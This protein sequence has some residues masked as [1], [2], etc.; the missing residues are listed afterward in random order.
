M[1][2][3]D[4]C[5]RNSCVWCTFCFNCLLSSVVFTNASPFYNTMEAI[6]KNQCGQ[7]FSE[8]QTKQIYHCTCKISRCKLS[9]VLTSRQN[10]YSPSSRAEI[11]TQLSST[12]CFHKLT[13][14]SPVDTASTLPVTDQL[15]LHTGASNCRSRDG[16]QPCSDCRHTYTVLSSEPLANMQ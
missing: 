15:T 6:M 9:C 2:R 10:C 4:H 5:R 3:N 1:F 7:Y 12:D 16:S 13:L 8:T 14:W 11:C